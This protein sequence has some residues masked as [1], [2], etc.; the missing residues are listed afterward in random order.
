MTYIINRKCLS[1]NVHIQI[2]FAIAY[3]GIYV[4]NENISKPKQMQ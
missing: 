4:R 3:F 1:C 2:I